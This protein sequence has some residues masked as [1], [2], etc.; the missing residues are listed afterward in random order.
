MIL[1][2]CIDDNVLFSKIKKE[3]FNK[4]PIQT[5]LKSKNFRV[6]KTFTSRKD[7]PENIVKDFNELFI[8]YYLFHQIKRNKFSPEELDNF[9]I[10]NKKNCQV[11]LAIAKNKHVK[12]ETLHYLLSTKFISVKKQ[13]VK[14]SNFSFESQLA[15]LNEKNNINKTMFINCLTMNKNMNKNILDKLIDLNIDGLNYSNIISNEKFALED[16]ICF[17]EKLN[18]KFISMYSIFNR[19]DLTEQVAF[20]ML[21]YLN[22]NIKTCDQYILRHLARKKHFI[23]L[24]KFLKIEKINNLLNI[25]INK[26][27]D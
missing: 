16:V 19:S 12:H 17:L 8:S 26:I 15:L 10:N 20:D 9:A 14:N 25:I 23:G 7:L 5:I 21:D 6:I 2:K 18:V 4:L 27:N 11:L 24:S 22:K 1:N 3:S 13:V